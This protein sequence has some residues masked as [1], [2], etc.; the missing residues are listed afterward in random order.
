MKKLF[1]LVA[2]LFSM[3]AFA[4][5]QGEDNG[6]GL[7]IHAGFYDSEKYGKIESD[8]D[9]GMFGDL[10]EDAMEE[11][12]EEM[13]EESG[14][15]DK[16]IPLFGMSIDNRWYVAKPGNFGIA[17]DARWLDF[18]IGK[19]SAS[20]EGEEFWKSTN[21]QA[22]L[23]M[24]GVIGTYY[25]GND[26]AIDVHYNVGATIAV[27]NAEWVNNE[28]DEAMD[29]LDDMGWGGLGNM[30]NSMLNSVYSSLGYEDGT[31]W[32]FGVSH[33][34]GASFRYKVFQAG[35]EYNVAK[36]KTVDWFDDDKDED[37][38]FESGLG[39]DFDDAMGE[40]FGTS[41]PKDTKVRF[42]NFRVFLGFK[43]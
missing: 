41:E 4:L 15:E 9:G 33:F 23:L 12:M 20:A 40:M 22:G 43:F 14:I 29:E 5:E 39:S 7:R 19:Q 42:N 38:D 25:L 10:M 17:I 30:M 31:S 34:F 24:P 6:F 3:S 32:G 16:K 1:L 26:M 28:A 18:G 36:L 8:N 27:K 35:F 21:I 37:S 13:K 2:T 11:G